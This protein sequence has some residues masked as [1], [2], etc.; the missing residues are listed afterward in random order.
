VSA[1][2]LVVVLVGALLVVV[3]AGLVRRQLLARVSGTVELSL[4]L[5]QAPGRGWVNGVGRFAGDEL[6]WYRVFSLSPRPRR[7][8]RRSALTVVERRPPIGAEQR[9]L[10]AGAL[11]L[12]C[13]VGDAPLQLA[14]AAPAVTGFLAWLEAR[15]PGA[16]LPG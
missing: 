5:S 7:R 2:D 6:H 9:A 15:P 4:R 8:Y 3:T 14:M 1:A 16:T 12:E 13:R 11:V 10:H